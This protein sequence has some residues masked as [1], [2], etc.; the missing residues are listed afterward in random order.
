MKF[1]IKIPG[2][3]HYSERESIQI[4][5]ILVE[6]VPKILERY[7][8][9]EPFEKKELD[10][11]VCGSVLTYSNCGI[12]YERDGELRIGCEEWWCTAKIEREARRLYKQ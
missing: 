4:N 1:G 9:R 8:L 10:C 12:M 11:R 3:A 2:L 7:N 5:V 6:D